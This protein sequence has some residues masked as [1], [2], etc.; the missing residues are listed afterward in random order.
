M[1]LF[2]PNPNYQNPQIMMVMKIEEN[3]DVYSFIIN[4]LNLVYDEKI[5]A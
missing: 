3:V 4:S 2:L 1:D 5:S